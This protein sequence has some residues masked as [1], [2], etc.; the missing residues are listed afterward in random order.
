MFLRSHQLSLEL[1]YISTSC[2]TCQELF[3]SFF[4]IL[5]CARCAPGEAVHHVTYLVYHANFYLSRTFS[6]FSKFSDILLPS[7]GRLAYTST[8]IP[9]C[10]ALFYKFYYSFLVFLTEVNL[11]FHGGLYVF[12]F[13][14]LSVRTIIPIFSQG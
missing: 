14:F 9:D 12:S 5:I 4:Q 3:S 8:L 2:R 7:A 6:C 10:Q 11:S 1:L 13:P